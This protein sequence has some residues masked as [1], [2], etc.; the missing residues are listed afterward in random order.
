MTTRN[1]NV[2]FCQNNMLAASGV[3]VTASG[4]KPG[5]PV[6]NLYSDFRYKLWQPPGTFEVTTSNQKLYINDGSDKTATITTGTYIYSTLATA[7]AAALNAVSSSWTCTYDFSGGTFKFTIGRTGTKTLRLT[8][9]TNAAWDMLG[10][11]GTADQDAAAADE[12]RNHTSEWFV[13]D[14]GVA[15]SPKAFFLRAAADGLFPLSASATVSLK[16]NNLNSFT[17]PALSRV[18]EVETDGITHWLDDLADTEYRYWKFEFSDRL[19]TVGP[20]GFGLNVAYLGD[21]VTL[22]QRNVGIGFN[23]QLVDP[24]ERT[25]S[26]SGVLYAR[27]RQKYWRFESMGI[28]ELTGSERTDLESFISDVGTTTPFFL[29]VDPTVTVS[30]S[31]GEF[32]KYVVFDQMPAMQHVRYDIWSY[33]FS[34]REV[35]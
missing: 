25:E 18:P 14:L 6:S 22:T 24:S 35:I 19:N 4:A 15:R 5:F 26:E 1:Q 29:A 9:T 7:V 3:T 34:V 16:G 27:R 33:G 28:S 13:V 17:S 21:Y 10:F 12:P 32:T 30:E 8:Q 20:E 2:R 23:R 31:A 11:A